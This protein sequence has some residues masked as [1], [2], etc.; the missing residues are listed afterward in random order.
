M[1]KNT[2]FLQVKNSKIAE[3]PKTVAEPLQLFSDVLSVIEEMFFGEKRM[4][5]SYRKCN[6]VW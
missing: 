4:E 2:E 3:R 5:V 6:F 1:L